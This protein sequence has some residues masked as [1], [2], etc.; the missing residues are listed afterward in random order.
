MARGVGIDGVNTSMPGRTIGA[1]CALDFE[2]LLV[3]LL[4]TVSVTLI[5]A[6]DDLDLES[7]EETGGDTESF[8]TE[9]SD[10]DDGGVLGLLILDRGRGGSAPI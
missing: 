8:L 10:D 1:L 7:F 9:S 5:S 2:S 3:W 4:P 6:D